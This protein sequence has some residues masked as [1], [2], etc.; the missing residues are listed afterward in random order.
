MTKRTLRFLIA[1]DHPLYREAVGAQIARFFAGAVVEEASNLDRL[2]KEGDFVGPRF[3]LLLVDLYMP[4]MSTSALRRLQARLPG[5][6]IAVISGAAT[7]A[8]IRECVQAGARGFIPKT[9]TGRQLA[10]AIEIL[11]DGGSTMPVDALLLES[12]SIRGEASAGGEDWLTTLDDRELAVLRGVVHG[13]SNKQIA[14]ELD[15]A[16]VTVKVYLRVLFRK[17]RVARRAQLAVFASQAGIT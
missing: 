2:L 4:G 10:S 6:P 7:A 14:R 9:A 8:A 12:G 11:L 13:K 1:D 3:D 15:I 5:I 17:V 16:E